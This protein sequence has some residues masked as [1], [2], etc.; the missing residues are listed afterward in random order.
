M[1][2]LTLDQINAMTAKTFRDA[3]GGVFEHSPWVSERAAGS[4]PF[5]SVA[6]LHAAMTEVVRRATREE[7][8]ALLRAHPDLA[9]KEAK[10]GTMTRDSTSEQGSAGLD[11]LSRDEI[12]RIDGLNRRYREQFGFPF[13]IAVRRHTKDGVFGEFERRLGNDAETELA[14]GLEQVFLITHLRLD[15]M[16][17]G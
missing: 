7:Q 9:G 15:A 11:A 4:R 5:A 12:E 17:S 3:L 8:L 13:I 6:A 1:P 2:S 16:I 14:N 10:T